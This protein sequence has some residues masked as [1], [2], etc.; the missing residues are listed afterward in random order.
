[1]AKKK[2]SLVAV[3]TKAKK[4][5]I[6]N[7][8]IDFAEASID[9]TRLRGERRE[10]F[11]QMVIRDPNELRHLVEWCKQAAEWMEDEK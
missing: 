2:T 3:K 1:M 8:G 4:P 11:I 9:K 6:I 10:V 5:K 7:L